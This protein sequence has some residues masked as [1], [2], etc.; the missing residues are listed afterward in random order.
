MR[1]QTEASVFDV[2][3]QVLENGGIGKWQYHQNIASGK[4]KSN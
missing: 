2:K 1:S 3:H 4:I